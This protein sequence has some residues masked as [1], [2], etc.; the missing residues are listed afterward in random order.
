MALSVRIS[1]IVEESIADGP[2]IRYALFTQGCPHQCKGCHNPETHT[3]DGGFLTDVATVLAQFKENPLLAGITFSGGEP[4]LQPEP[5]WVLA[6]QIKALGKTVVVFSGYTCEHLHKLSVKQPAVAGLLALTDLLIDGPY[7]EEQRDL[8]LLY[9][10]SGNQRI[11][12]KAARS[13]L[14]RGPERIA[15]QQYASSQSEPTPHTAYTS[16]TTLSC[17]RHQPA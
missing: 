15:T 17:L 3:L 8:E 1:G 10:G 4:F 7:I 9:R 6:E 2:G 14:C 13:W 16:V 11:L 12:D 5:L